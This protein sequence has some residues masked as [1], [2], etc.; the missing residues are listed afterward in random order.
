MIYIKNIVVLCVLLNLFMFL[1]LKH[2]SISQ[3]DYRLHFLPSMFA[4]IIGVLISRIYILNTDLKTE[5][6]KLKKLLDDK[7][8]LLKET[9]HRIKN[10]LQ[11][12]SSLLSIQ[13]SFYSN[14]EVKKIFEKSQNRINSMANIHE[15]MYHSGQISDIKI[16][17]YLKLLVKGIIDTMM[18]EED[19]I[20]FDFD[21]DD[22][23]FNLNTI[24]PLALIIN[25]IITNS[26]KYGFMNDGGRIFLSLKFM[27]KD[28]FKMIIGD[29][30]IGIK[31][32][33]N[34]SIKSLGTE[35]IKNLASQLNGK[36][37]LKDTETG[38]V[39]EMIFSKI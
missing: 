32:S 28:K 16:S 27:D 11:S 25:E 22:I 19:K 1:N 4:L 31:Q 38:T 30:G 20:Q 35:L 34:K 39:Y 14:N 6:Q 5:K 7:E 10:N 2:F 33:P 26:L 8:I 3:Y 24:V 18:I 9:H 15:M 29:N 37:E 21:T 36:I 23:S 17:I 13:S 12:I